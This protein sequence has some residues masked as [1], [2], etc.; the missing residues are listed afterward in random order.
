MVSSG[1]TQEGWRWLAQESLFLVVLGHRASRLMQA[2]CNGLGL[3]GGPVDAGSLQQG[4]VAGDN[5]SGHGHNTTAAKKKSRQ[6]CACHTA[7]KQPGQPHESNP[8]RGVHERAGLACDRCRDIVSP[9]FCLH[10]KRK[11]VYVWGRLAACADQR[12]TGV[13]SR[14]CDGRAVQA[15]CPMTPFSNGAAQRAASC[16]SSHPAPEAAGPLAQA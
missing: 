12:A 6:G 8:R 7:G 10:Y 9:S 4:L 5:G 14:P 3:P 1:R 15:Q 11:H 13:T 2:G 16:A